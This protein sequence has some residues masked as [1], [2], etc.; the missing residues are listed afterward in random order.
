MKKIIIAGVAII[1]LV[2]GIAFFT[3]SNLGPLVKKTINTLGPQI[4][5]TD[6]KVEDV[7]ISIFSGQAT[8]KQFFL[9]N[10]KGFKS[11]QAMKVASIYVD[12]DEGSITKNPII[13]NKIEIIAPEITYEKI[14]D[15]DNF[16]AILKNV[17]GSAKED[18]KS[19]KKSDA[20][21]DKKSK[22]II[23]N[24]VIIKQGKVHLTMAALAGKE[25]TAPL[26][27]IHLTDIGKKTNG[28]TAAQA[29]E[30]IFASLYSNISADAVTKIF[31][32]SLKQLGDIKIPENLQDIGSTDSES[33]KKAIDSV[34]KGLKNLFKK[35]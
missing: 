22:K 3:L 7:S 25:I 30:K 9:G 15:S 14:K 12:I 5:K 1:F 4:T 23:I 29:F 8:I 31:N 11:A 18:G 34:S 2:A 27:D 16:Q 26:P 17:Q 10:P 28:A 20:G 13:I 6:V 33:A 24:D 21:K 19:E 32:D 35:E